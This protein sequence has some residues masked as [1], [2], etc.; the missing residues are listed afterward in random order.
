MLK[1]TTRAPFASEKWRPLTGIAAVSA[2]AVAAA[3]AAAA[4]AA[5]AAAH[6]L[7]ACCFSPCLVEPSVAPGS[8]CITHVFVTRTQMCYNPITSASTSFRNATCGQK[9]TKHNS[10]LNALRLQHIHS[11]QSM[12]SNPTQSHQMQQHRSLSIRIPQFLT[13][14][15]ASLE[16]RLSV[17]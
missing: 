6:I 14:V 2:A 16:K 1:L 3:A 5:D 15:S 4:A 7:K 11:A 10:T 13:K 8:Y 17:L 9:S 12:D